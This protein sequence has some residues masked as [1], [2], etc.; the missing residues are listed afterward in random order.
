MN[1]KVDYNA[2]SPIL[3]SSISMIQV[4]KKVQSLADKAGLLLPEVEAGA[5][6]L[7]WSIPGDEWV[8]LT[9]LDGTARQKAEQT[10]EERTA[11][12]KQLM[13]G[14]PVAE[15]V[16]TVP[17][18]EYVY[19]RQQGE[20]IDIAL[21]AWGYR[22]PTKVE[23]GPVSTG[24]EPTLTEEVEI[25]F[26]WD[27]RR[28]IKLPFKLNGKSRITDSRGSFA[29]DGRVRV[30]MELELEA[31]RQVFGLTVEKGRKEY[32]YDLTER[33]T[34]DVQVMRDGA[35]WAEVSCLLRMGDRRL[36]LTTDAAGHATASLALL[37]DKKGF[38]AVP[39]P[40][41]VVECEGQTQVQ[42]PAGAGDELL[43]SFMMESP[44]EPPAVTAEPPAET[45]EPPA[46]TVEP[47]AVRK[48]ITLEF[49]DRKGKPLAGVT[50][51]V[52][53]TSGEP[54]T[55]KTDEDGKA[56]LERDRFK[57]GEKPKVEFVLS[58]EYQQNN[59]GTYR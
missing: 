48:K 32:V 20:R 21:M 52:T 7:Q 31:G 13:A 10:L 37:P 58:K 43:Y 27:G 55:V 5:G 45:A 19:V 17:G 35:P 30:G 41:C 42:T 23:G 9:S 2:L 38:I 1:R 56:Q 33:F 34:I 14:A 51:K 47:P 28:M 49:L 12:L 4:G 36:Q 15:A 3:G 40:E 24:Y 44:T 16:C 22:Y 53:G 25:A 11:Q 46:E 59:P 26:E 57:P 39:Q 6:Y 18:G 29:I 8:P 50:I 54:I